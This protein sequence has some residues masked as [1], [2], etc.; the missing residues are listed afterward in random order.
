MLRDA[1][2]VVAEKFGIPIDRYRMIGTR[3]G[4]IFEG[5]SIYDTPELIAQEIKDGNYTPI[6]AAAFGFLIGT[7]AGRTMY[8]KWVNRND[9]A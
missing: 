9:G 8:E 6:E 1:E 2:E 3:L 7:I 4:S 5:T